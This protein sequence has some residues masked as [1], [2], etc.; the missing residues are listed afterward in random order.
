MRG[1]E[2]LLQM[3]RSGLRPRTVTLLTAPGWD[4][5][6][7]NWPAVCPEFPELEI[8]PDETPERLDLRCLIGLPVHVLGTDEARVER[9][10]KCA[11]AAGAQRAMGS[12][13]RADGPGLDLIRMTDTEGAVIWPN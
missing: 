13:F 7:S 4:R 10:A 9:I 11:M 12:V 1:H 2:P 5:W 8:A 3:R 6:V